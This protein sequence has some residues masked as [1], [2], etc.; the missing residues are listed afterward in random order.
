MTDT[1]HEIQVEELTLLATLPKDAGGSLTDELED[2]LTEEHGI[3][4]VRHIED[5]DVEAV[6]ERDDVLELYASMDV[7]VHLDTA[8]LDND[9]FN[10]ESGVRSL[11]SFVVSK[12]QEVEAIGGFNIREHYEVEAY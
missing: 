12:P 3:G 11:T 9:Y 5:L 4:L 1:V 6:T 8:S 2:K 10:D 7:T